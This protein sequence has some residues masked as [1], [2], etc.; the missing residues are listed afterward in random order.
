MCTNR[1]LPLAGCLQPENFAE[2]HGL[3]VLAMLTVLLTLALWPFTVDAGFKCVCVR[4][5]VC[6]CVRARARE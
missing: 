3:A 1:F 4:A 2:T 6:V 5:R